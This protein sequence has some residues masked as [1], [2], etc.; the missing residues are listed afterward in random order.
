[1]Q[2]KAGHSTNDYDKLYELLLTDILLQTV[3]RSQIES[4]ITFVS[5]ARTVL[6]YF[7]NIANAHV[8]FLSVLFLNL[9]Q[10]TFCRIADA[11]S[12]EES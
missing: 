12:L 8:L 3:T 7:F 6:A 11:F 1:M 2:R 4:I 10:E 5:K 9:R